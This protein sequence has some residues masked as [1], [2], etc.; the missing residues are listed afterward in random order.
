MNTHLILAEKGFRELD[1][2]T[3]VKLTQLH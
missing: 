1:T 3:F 2:S